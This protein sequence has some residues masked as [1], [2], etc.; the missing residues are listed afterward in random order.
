MNRN[1]RVN[2]EDVMIAPGTRQLKISLSACAPKE[3]DKSPMING[4][5]SRITSMGT[6]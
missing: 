6:V 5:N 2:E 3:P 1:W 4:E